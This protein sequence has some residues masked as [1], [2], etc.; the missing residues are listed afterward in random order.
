M[1]QPIQNRDDLVQWVPFALS[2]DDK[3]LT[4]AWARLADNTCVDQKSVV[5]NPDDTPENTDCNQKSQHIKKTA[6]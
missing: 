1:E 6:S 3:M 2:D 5:I 4:S